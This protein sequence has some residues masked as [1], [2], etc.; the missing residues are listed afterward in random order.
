M[1]ITAKIRVK[2]GRFSVKMGDVWTICVKS[3]ADRGL[4]NKEIING[5]GRIYEN[6]RILKGLKSQKKTIFLGS[7]KA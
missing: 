7:K 4:A 6:V 2:Q 5:L 1:I 3:P